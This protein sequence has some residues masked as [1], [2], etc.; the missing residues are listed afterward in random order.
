MRCDSLAW[1][2]ALRFGQHLYGFEGID[3]DL[4][5]GHGSVYL[6]LDSLA[7]QLI[8]SERYMQTL[9]EGEV[10][11]YMS[12]D[13]DDIWRERCEFKNPRL[14][15]ERK[16]AWTAR[17]N[18]DFE[19]ENLRHQ[20]AARYVDF[21]QLVDFVVEMTSNNESLAAF[22][23]DH[24]VNAVYDSRSNRWVDLTAIVGFCPECE[25]LML[26]DDLVTA[27]SDVQPHVF[28]REECPCEHIVSSMMCNFDHHASPRSMVI[29]PNCDFAA[30]TDNIEETWAE[31]FSIPLEWPPNAPYPPRRG[32]AGE[33]LDVPFYEE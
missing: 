10:A 33:P 9:H 19:D 2:R 30:A 26:P 25:S 22:L 27:R 5:N 28:T 24:P 31:R 4:G 1:A 18:E 8:S 17:V 12:E 20:W 32:F 11:Q 16:K 13:W 23:R 7:R 6:K 21:D 29:C 14:W 3:R 15:K